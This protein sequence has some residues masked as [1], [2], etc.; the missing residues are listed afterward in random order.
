MALQPLKGFLIPD[1][2]RNPA[3]APGTNSL[4]IDAASEKVAMI[5]Q[6]PKTG[7][8]DR[9]YFKTGTVTTGATVDVRLETV[10]SATGDPTGTLVAAN[11][12]ASQVIGN[13]DDNVWFEVTLTAAGAVTRG[14]F[15]A[16]VVVNPAGS[17]GNLSIHELNDDAV[18]SAYTTLFT[19][20][21]TKQVGSSIGA[22]R[23]NDGSYDYMPGFWPFNAIN[24]LAI[25]TGTTP[26]E[27]GLIFQLPF[28]VRV[29]GAWVW[30]DFDGDADIKLYD[31]DGTTV[32]ASI[33]T[34]LNIR[35]VTSGDVHIFFFT[36]SAELLKNTNYRLSL[37]PTTATSLT[38]YEYQMTSA[39]LLNI[40]AGGQAFHRTD[41]TDAGAWAQTTTKRPQMGLV[42]D[43]F[44]D[45]VGGGSSG[46]PV[47]I[48][49]AGGLSLPVY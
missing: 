46:G 39:E 33:S 34:D 15:Y 31:S 20:V 48:M 30:A 13:S 22:V 17:P 32:L 44:D 29:A 11:T 3:G 23:Y 1:I 35:R 40:M 16:I 27:V 7:S 8:I 9:V 2:P 24:S 49:R 10:D 4:T 6:A 25:N 36:A 47:Q 14:T 19:T 41:R 26:D 5:F 18:G 45:G 38:L 42:L 43:A 28:P 37:L 12:N 21:W